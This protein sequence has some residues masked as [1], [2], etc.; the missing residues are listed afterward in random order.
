M[1]IKQ[2]GVEGAFIPRLKSRVSCAKRMNINRYALRKER[3]LQ[4]II[5]NQPKP[6]TTAIGVC[7]ET[8]VT[9]HIITK[10]SEEC[11]PI[12]VFVPKHKEGDG[13][14]FPV[15]ID[16]YGGG[17]VAGR[18]EQNKC[19]G[20]WCAEHGYLT[21]IPEYT[22]VPETNIFG[23]I[24]DILKAFEAIDLLADNY[25]GDKSKMY[26]VGD[27]AGAALA[28]L[29][30]ALIW[31]PVSMRH[32]DDELPFNIPQSAKLSFRAMC[33]QNGIFTL[34]DGKTAAI[35]PYLMEKGWQRTSYAPYV[36]P[37]TYAKMLPP[38]FLV[39]GISDS[40]KKDTK[41]FSNLLVHKRIKCKMYITHT[42]FT[43]ESFAARYPGK[44]YSE[45]ANLEML[46][47]FEKI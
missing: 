8:Q 4:K 40:Q 47:F 21:F 24:G 28:C 6:N 38:C 14:K 43:K 3:S 2:K 33:L 36:S 42:P 23:Q 18:S 11:L 31:H 7:S 45:A 32:L 5:K 44:P 41:R 16:I 10:R 27:G 39:T 17:F 37:K 26:L 15:I 34:T 20:A 12:S 30:Y 25:A 19:F 22:P 13:K 35:T 29:T 9:H 46:K 1:I